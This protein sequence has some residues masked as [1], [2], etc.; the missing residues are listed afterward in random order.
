MALGQLSSRSLTPST[1][2]WEATAFPPSIVHTW[3]IFTTARSPASSHGFPAPPRVA[4]GYELLR[5]HRE[6][7]ADLPAA[8][9]G[10][11]QPTPFCSL[12][13][14]VQLPARRSHPLFSV[15]YYLLSKTTILC[16]NGRADRRI[17]F[18]HSELIELQLEIMDRY[19][20]LIAPG[21]CLIGS[22]FTFVRLLPR[23]P[24]CALSLFER[25]P[26]APQLVSPLRYL[27]PAVG[28]SLPPRRHGRAFCLAPSTRLCHSVGSGGRSEPGIP[29]SSRQSPLPQHRSRLFVGQC[30]G[31]RALEFARHPGRE[32]NPSSAGYAPSRSGQRSD[33]LVTLSG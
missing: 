18:L 27:R 20:Q 16:G 17:R 24:Q 30:R 2:C 13:K 6:V 5:H 32:W 8:I 31:K 25:Q 11:W 7:I 21:A 19:S 29:Q 22:A 26:S 4:V 10:H 12:S 28:F 1:C 14:C 23:G 9:C 33:D 15:Y 3:T